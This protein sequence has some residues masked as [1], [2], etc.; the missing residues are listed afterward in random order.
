VAVTREIQVTTT[1]AETSD[2]GDDHRVQEREREV[3]SEE[4][5]EIDEQIQ[6]WRRRRCP[7]LESGSIGRVRGGSAWRSRTRAYCEG[8]SAS[9]RRPQ[10]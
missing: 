1:F 4:E 7:P 9:W 3:E 10:P 5:E 8:W 6:S 2:L